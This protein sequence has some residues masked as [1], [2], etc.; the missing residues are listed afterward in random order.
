MTN[1]K[2]IKPEDAERGFYKEYFTLADV[3]T[4]LENE[5]NGF[6][7]LETVQKE[8]GAK[9]FSGP[10][11]INAF[12]I[13]K[14]EVKAGPFH[15]FLTWYLVT[16]QLTEYSRWLEVETVSDIRK[17]KNEAENANVYLTSQKGSYRKEAKG[18]ND[19]RNEVK[20]DLRNDAK[21]DLNDNGNW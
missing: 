2:F 19:H 11:M 10:Q 15:K 5:P 6:N 18:Q 12:K 20:K 13:Y 4:H 16:D 8:Y 3:L 1:K 7:F 17:A 21:R 9:N 14:Q